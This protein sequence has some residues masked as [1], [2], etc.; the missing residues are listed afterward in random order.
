MEK[1]EL[2][3][4]TVSV[5]AF[6]SAMGLTPLNQTQHKTMEL[7]SSDINRPGLQFTGYFDHFASERVQIIGKAEMTYYEQTALNVRRERIE[8]YMRAQPPCIIISRSMACPKDMLECACKHD[9]PVFSSSLITTHLSARISLHLNN[10]L[11]P[12]ITMHGVLIDVFGVGILLTGD[13]GIG[14]SET[15]LEMVKRGHSLVADDVVIAKRVNETRLVGEA[16]ESIR[17]FIEIR[18]VGL[19]NV[20][21]M[22]G[23]SAVT[24]TKSI[25]LNVH[26]EPGDFQKHYARIGSE[27]DFA[28]INGVSVPKLIIPVVPGRNLAIVLEAAAR[29]H[30]LKSTGYDSSADLTRRIDE[31][32]A[33]NSQNYKNI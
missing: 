2:V 8:R 9:V 18:G 3:Y 27:K 11:A 16:P 25:D 30:L 32:I 10:V 7:A 17:N 13:S 20:S 1:E 21:L 12:K 4:Q 5:E 33:A 19:V 31:M 22:F 24:K 14:K 26:L 23:V 29:N 28:I 15:A 6:T